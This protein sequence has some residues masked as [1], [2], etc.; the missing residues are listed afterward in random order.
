MGKVHDVS[1]FKPELSLIVDP[2]IRELTEK[3]LTEMPAYIWS[4]VSSITGKY[5]PPEDNQPGGVLLHLKKTSWVAYRIF[6]NLGL[7]TDIG[8][9]AGLTHDIALRGLEAQPS[10]EFEVYEQHGELAYERLNEY[11]V[12]LIGMPDRLTTDWHTICNCVQS[13]MGRWGKE[14]PTSP[15]EVALHC[16]DVAASTRGLA[17]IPFIRSQ[18]LL[19]NGFIAEEIPDMPIEEI[20]GRKEFFVTDGEGN[21]VFSFGK[22]EGRTLADV[23]G[24]YQISGYLQWMIGQGMKSM[25]NE[26]GFPLY[27]LKEVRDA[28]LEARKPKNPDLIDL[29]KEGVE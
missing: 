13:H 28:I 3:V 8:V 22:M 11:I 20:V 12:Q 9:S 15:E 4:A 18:Y 26:K 17:G 1:I 21:R 16:A 27:V 5:H 19:K 7:N 14:K 23:A 25:K 10:D 29:M 2:N 24:D 6:D